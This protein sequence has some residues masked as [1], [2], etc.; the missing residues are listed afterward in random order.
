L[1]T[2]IVHRSND[3]SFTASLRRE[4]LRESRVPACYLSRRPVRSHVQFYSPAFAI[5]SLAGLSPKSAIMM[6]IHFLL[7][8]RTSTVESILLHA[9]GQGAV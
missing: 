6:G 1:L 9:N 7:H 8:N 5:F 2:L 4:A 3:V